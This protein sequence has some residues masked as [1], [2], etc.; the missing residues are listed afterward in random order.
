MENNKEG[1]D[2]K[3]ENIGNHTEFPKKFNREVSQGFRNDSK[4]P[5]KHKIR[6]LL[7]A[8]S[9]SQNDLARETGLSKG[10]VSKIVNGEWWPSSDTMRIISES[11]GVD[12]SVIFGEEEYWLKWRDRIK[13][14]KEEGE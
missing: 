6:V 4:I 5:L 13:Y 8:K 9:M 14:P 3:N 7:D 10:T 1:K 12:S 2:V 11:L